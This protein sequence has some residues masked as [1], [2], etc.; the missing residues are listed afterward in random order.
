[1]AGRED[2]S[3]W[4]GRA[5]SPRR[6]ARCNRQRKAGGSRLPKCPCIPCSHP[7]SCLL[8]R[9]RRQ[10]HAYRREQKSPLVHS[11]DE[12]AHSPPVVPP[13]FRASLTPSDDDS[14]RAWR[15][16]SPITEASAAIYPALCRSLEGCL[17]GWYNRAPRPACGS[18]SVATVLCRGKGEA[19][20]ARRMFIMHSICSRSVSRA[21]RYRNQQIRPHTGQGR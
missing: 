8:R 11:R 12:R 16:Q 9:M 21:T 15:A 6:R 19:C 5:V 4:K 13:T 18:Q 10:M 17:R 3:H 7:S 1:M 20:P 14:D 2:E